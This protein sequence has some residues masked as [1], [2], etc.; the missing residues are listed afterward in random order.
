MRRQPRVFFSFRSP[1]SWLALE[2][3]R[4]R[5]AQVWAELEMIPYWE[6]DAETAR[7]LA[8]RGAELHY[9]PMSKAK[10]LYILHDTRR[11][12]EALGFRLVWPVDV[13]PW[14]ELPHL[15]WLQ[16]RRLGRGEAFYDAVTRARWLAGENICDRDVIRRLAGVAGL[17]GDQLV[18]SV[19]TPELRAEGVE[20]LYDAWNDDIFGVPYFRN[21]RH[22]FWGADR[23]DS[24]LESLGAAS[25]P[26]AALPEAVQAAVGAYD[27]DTS[28]GCG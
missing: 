22:R 23:V 19:E 26:E 1:F 14:W 4:R 3:L 9:A 13:A 11:L 7:A 20:A 8:G 28:G 12:A 17:D 16:A 5:A 6:P 27:H 25:A 18:P 10:H 15:A 2:R 21:G 24:F